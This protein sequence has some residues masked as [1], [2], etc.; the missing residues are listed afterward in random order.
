[1]IKPILLSCP[2]YEFSG[3]LD[4]KKVSQCIDNTLVN[5]FEGKKVVI[6]GIQSKKHTLPKEKLIQQIV[7]TGSDRYASTGKH[8]V[9][10]SKDPIDLF[11][12][13]CIIKKSP[14]VLPTL[15][16]FHKWKPKSLERP[17]LKLDIWMIY[18]ASQLENIEYFH[19]YYGVKA[20]D[21]YIFKNPKDKTSALLGVVVIQ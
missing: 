10:V 3:E 18:D 5:K 20:K 14:I 2:C 9:R 21:G 19:S 8:E 4:L 7:Q 13:G 15:E 17:Q 12:Y 16:G 11:G 6:R 1:M